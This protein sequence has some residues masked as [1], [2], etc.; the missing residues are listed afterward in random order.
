LGQTR[1]AIELHEQALAIH[2]EIGDRQ[3]EGAD[4][5]NL[6]SRYSELGDFQRALGYYQLAL[7]NAREIGNRYGEA[8]RLR[9]VAEVFIDQTYYTQALSHLQESAKIGAELNSPEVNNETHYFLALAHLFSG[10]LPAARAA[11]EQ[12]RRYDVPQNNHNVLA[13]LGVVALRQNDAPA[14]REAFAASLAHAESLLTQTPEY[15]GA[16][17][18]RALALAGLGQI[19]EAHAA[20]QAAR[21]VNSD[22]GVVQRA[23]RLLSQLK[24]VPRFWEE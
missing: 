7:A 24:G 20:Y 6:G 18:A 3:G 21:A 10:D 14:A 13:L 4:L 16:L 1:R 23:T 2:R 12:A 11:A 9:G 19:E 5:S 22:A 15:L 8:K 17:D